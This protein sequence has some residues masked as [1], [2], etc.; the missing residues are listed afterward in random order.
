MQ[1]I[2]GDPEQIQQSVRATS[3][4]TIENNQ[5]NYQPSLFTKEYNYTWQEQQH[6]PGESW[7]GR[8]QYS[9]GQHTFVNI[10]YMQ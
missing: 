1:D 10:Q 5:S 7:T 6:Q 8:L 2:H 3:R 9:C 4:A